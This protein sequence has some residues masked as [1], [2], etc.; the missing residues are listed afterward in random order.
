MRTLIGLILAPFVL[1]ILLIKVLFWP[2]VFVTLAYWAFGDK[3][4]W[5]TGTLLFCIAWA[6]VD[7]RALKRGRRKPRIRRKAK[8]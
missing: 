6:V 1:A 4:G 5:F 8:R 2:V 3:S 7:Y